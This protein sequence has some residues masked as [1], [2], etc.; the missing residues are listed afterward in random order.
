MKKFYLYNSPIP[1]TAQFELFPAINDKTIVVISPHADDISI[2]CG[3]TMAL[4][5]T[6]NTIFPLLC[7]TGERG[8]IAAT[9][10]KRIA[11]REQE[12][13]HEAH[14]LGLQQPTFLQLSSYETETEP[15]KKL[16]ISRI[17]KEFQKRSPDIVFLPHEQDCQP[18]HHL[19][20]VLALRAL[21]QAALSPLLFFYETVWHPFGPLDF[22]IGWVLN[23]ELMAKKL[24]AIRVHASQ[25][26]RTRFDVAAH[27]LAQLRAVTVPE[28]RIGG[29]GHTIKHKQFDYMEVFLTKKYK[30]S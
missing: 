10:K 16:D 4:L 21:N 11:I 14:I 2:A 24:T 9:K 7:F 30:K 12:M 8:V 25:L 17:A 20:T 5:S 27:A 28:Q 3:G 6:T 1:S 13:L 22:N 15:H 18:R 26:Q 23:K 29:Y 19:A